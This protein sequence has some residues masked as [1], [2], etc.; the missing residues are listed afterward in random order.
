MEKY[1]S[2]GV[3]GH[4]DHGKTSLVHCL[5]G[6]N[7]DRMKAEKKRGL[8]IETGIA[9][10]SLPSGKNVALVDVPGHTD[11]LKNTVRGL[12]AV[13]MAVLV[14]AADDGVMPQTVEHLKILEFLNVQGGIAVISKSDLADPETLE[15]AGLETEELVQGT[16]LEGKPFLAFSAKDEKGKTEIL[17]A[18]DRETALLKGKETE[19][20]FRLR[21][22]QVRSFPGIGTV[23]SGTVLSGILHKDDILELL[24]SGLKT[25]ARSLEVHGIKTDR[26]SAGQRAGINLHRVS[27]E[28]LCRGMM[29]SPPGE[30]PCT[31][32]LNAEICMGEQQSALLKNR[33][34]VRLFPGTSMIAATVLLME[35]EELRAGEK[36]LAQFRCESLLP[37]IPGEHFVISLMNVPAV[38]GGGRI[39]EI[40][41]CKFRPSKAAKIIPCLRTVREKNIPALLDRVPEIISLDAEKLSRRTGLPR[42]AFASEIESRIRKGHLVEISGCGIFR[43]DVYEHTLT[44]VQEIIRSTLKDDPMK[45]SMN[46]AEIRK[47][48]GEEPLTDLLIRHLLAELEEKGKIV[49]EKGG[50]CLPNLECELSAKHRDITKQLLDFAETA[51]VRPFSV[52]AAWKNCPNPC[53]KSEVE[54][55]LDYLSR[56]QQLTCLNNR[57]FLSPR[58]LEEIKGRVRDFILQK[59]SMHPGDSAKLLGYGRM[60]AVP[61]LEY[62]DKIGFT[63]RKGD[64]RLLKEKYADRA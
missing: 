39:L 1:I 14:V 26:V 4:V 48:A 13:D 5:S 55:L 33:Q 25:R 52:H 3:A 61:V 51:G 37:C 15:L 6:V 45:S 57:R 46:A 50:Y 60:G 12:S 35:K 41:E 40:P 17:A 10:L 62:L 64:D 36:G 19:A 44:A 53:S 49:R 63:F 20:P 59:G 21:I 56:K 7:T 9:R 24:P 29:L 8:S 38:I 31:R 27:A 30:T 54:R 16:F 47:K 58:A 23:I 22:D 18:L 42:K 43:K 34:K 32:L 11:F 28:N 2:I